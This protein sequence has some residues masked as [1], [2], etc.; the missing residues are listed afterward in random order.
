MAGSPI[1]HERNRVWREALTRA[2]LKKHGNPEGD[3]I[4]ALQSIAEKVVK[5]ADEGPTGEKGD[6]WMRAVQELG[7]RFDGKPG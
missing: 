5:T 3:V 4:D 2:L 7:D 1:K 6:P